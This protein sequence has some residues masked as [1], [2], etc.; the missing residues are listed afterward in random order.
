MT[1]RLKLR[2][3]VKI[4]VACLAVVVGLSSCKKEVT[5]ISLDKTTLTLEVGEWKT[6]TATVLPKNATNKSVA[7]TTSNG[8]IASVVDG[9]VNGNMAGTTT[10]IAKAG[11]YTTTCEVTVKPESLEGTN[12][13]GT[14]NYEIQWTLNFTNATNCTMTESYQGETVTAT[15][16]YIFNSPNIS[17]NLGGGLHL[18]GTVVGNQMT[19]TIGGSHTVSLTKQ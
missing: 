7:W 19:L 15:G 18:S 12:W 14:D 10:V 13:E 5:G 1:K 17:I 2:N 9:I 11:N 4:G 16:T 3:V 6:L 8:T